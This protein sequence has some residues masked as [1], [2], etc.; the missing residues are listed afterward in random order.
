VTSALHAL[1]KKYDPLKSVQMFV[2]MGDE[3]MLE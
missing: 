1:L 3:E 2:D